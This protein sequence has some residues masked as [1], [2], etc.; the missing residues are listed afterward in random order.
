MKINIFPPLQKSLLALLGPSVIFVA[1]SLNG[2]E[3]LLWPDLVSRYGL[4]LLWIVPIILVLQY[5]VNIEIERY[6]LTTGNN[7]LIALVAQYPKLKIIFL[8]SIIISLVWPAWVLISGNILAVTIGQAQLGIMLSIITLILIISLWFS[9]QS[10]KIIELIT[11]VGL[12]ILFVIII[13]LLS[14]KFDLN[15]ISQSFSSQLIPDKVDRYLY[16]SALAFGGVTG[17][18]NLVQSSWIQNKKYGASVFEPNSVIDYH[19]PESKKNWKQWFRIITIE[20]SVLFI[21]GNIFGIFLIS[22]IAILTIKDSNLKGFNI[23]TYQVNNL[24]SENQLVG[25]AWGVC[26][27]ILFFMAQVTILDAS[28]HLIKSILNSTKLSAN[29]Y[30]QLTGLVGLLILILIAINPQFNLPSIILQISASLSAFIMIFYPPLILIMNQ[31]N[32][33]EYARPKLIN[34]IGVICCSI[35]YCLVCLWA[36]L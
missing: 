34:Y 22:I 10:Y 20:H 31:N 26:I 23:L 33:P 12:T 13:Y 4:Q 17:I 18:L 15:L 19:N 14:N 35:F 21:G 32:L 25:I 16:L 24:T 8:L 3:M 27:A 7:T 28:G 2:G 29:R 11:K 9:E 6:T 5:S 36:V 1:L 30:S